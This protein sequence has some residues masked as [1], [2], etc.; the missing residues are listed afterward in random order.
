MGSPFCNNVKNQPN[1]DQNYPKKPLSPCV[2]EAEKI[3]YIYNW[4]DYIPTDLLEKFKK[5]TGIQVVYSAFDS[6]EVLE[7]QLLLDAQYDVVFP[8]AWPAMVRGIQTNRFL[9]L[10]KD[11]IPNIHN[12]DPTISKKL[13]SD[14]QDLNYGVPYLWGTTG[15]GY[16]R[17]AILAR[18]PKAPLD[19]WA[20]IFDPRWAELLKEGHIFLLDSVTD[21]LQAALLHLGKPVNSQDL[22]IWDKAVTHIMKI[23]PYIAAFE[24]S[25]QM[26]NLLSGN[27]EIMQGFSTYVQ[28]AMEE[29][30]N[31]A[32]D[33]R[34]II[35]KEGS[36]IWI[37]MM[38][39]PKN[40]RH[41]KNAHLFIN[42]MLRPENM[43]QCTN[44]QKAANAVPKSY[45]M[46]H[47]DLLSNPTI[48]PNAQTMER[49]YPDF[50]PSPSLSRHLCRQWCK[51]KMNYRPSSSF[52]SFWSFW[53][54]SKLCKKEEKNID[55]K[56]VFSAQPDVK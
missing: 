6:I 8:S 50:L 48:F 3:L 22:A 1:H 45:P 16:D 9:P 37:D 15:I 31:N 54:F 49:I 52:W 38:A 35:P 40:A 24:G 14:N 56:A 43:A 44:I 29:N 46:I 19:S 10:R 25:K 5:E 7:A 13:G 12:I 26:E 23:R 32:R 55:E 33:I 20:L 18:A 30:S 34:Y 28:M 11:W 51:I 39:I 17:N 47:P 41:P 27:N 36:V 53:P 2:G 4:A 21:V 42:F